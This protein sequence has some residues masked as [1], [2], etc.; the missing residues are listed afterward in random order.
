MLLLDASAEPPTA[1]AVLTARQLL[2]RGRLRRDLEHLRRQLRRLWPS[3]E[4]FVALE[5]Q[6][7]GAIHLNLL[8]KG[9]R[10]GAI[11]LF[12]KVV[13]RAWLR[14]VDAVAAAQ[15][16]Q[17]ISTWH[18]LSRYVLGLVR[19]ITKADQAAPPG[20]RGHRTSQTR[21]Y[22]VRP[23]A[24]MRPEARMSLAYKRLRACYLRA[25]LSPVEASW[26]AVDDVLARQDDEWVL[27][28][29]NPPIGAQCR[30]SAEP[31]S[32]LEWLSWDEPAEEAGRE[33]AHVERGVKSAV[34]LD[35]V[36]TVRD[37]VRDFSRPLGAPQSVARSRVARDCL[38]QLSLKLGPSRR[39]EVE[40]WA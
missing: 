28:P 8:V 19:Y 10:E 21:G 1:Y 22:L 20:W 11:D 35:G 31:V 23:A 18:A 2:D 27:Y 29:L 17:S 32:A 12:R 37:A 14:R 30:G 16:I 5:W 38:A 3:V 9:V 6:R 24:V 4:W 34:V 36:P 7:R 13:L 40:T 33:Q 15:C 39:W 26:R 25:G